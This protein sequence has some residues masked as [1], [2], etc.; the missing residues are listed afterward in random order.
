MKKGLLSFI[1]LLLLFTSTVFTTALEPVNLEGVNPAGRFLV[2]MRS[3][4]ESLGATVHWEASTRTV[5]GT[6]G[7]TVVDL[8]IDNANAYINGELFILDAPAI[9]VN[10]STYVPARFVGEALGATVGWDGT[11]RMASIKLD[12][13]L[14]HIYEELP[15][16]PEIIVVDNISYSTNPRV[17]RNGGNQR[18]TFEAVVKDDDGN[19]IEGAE[20]NFFVSSREINVSDAVV[21]ESKLT[22][23]NGLVRASYT[24]TARDNDKQFIVYVAAFYDGANYDAMTNFVV[25]NDDTARITGTVY[26]PSTGLPATDARITA[27]QRNPDVHKEVA[28]TDAHGRYDGF[29]PISSK[30]YFIGVSFENELLDV[31]QTYQSSQSFISPDRF[32]LELRADI[33][34]ANEVY[35]IDFEHGF[36]KGTTTNNAKLYLIPIINGVPRDR[37]GIAFDALSNGT[38][39]A[40][41]PVGTYE[42]VNIRTESTI[43]R[44]IVITKGEVTDLGTHNR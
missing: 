24:T 17:V 37:E 21:Y 41:L 18:V 42:M 9:I 14:V 19:P 7:D 34:K 35:E 4:F 1:L 38:Y 30:Q 40:P 5:T 11:K 39:L 8:T 10:S 36:I 29:I 3:I 32:S 28:F 2:P 44:N 16:E 20:V 15:P 27:S 12:D 23:E 6:K 31:N 22:D 25:T 33:N 13:I 26:H 43:R